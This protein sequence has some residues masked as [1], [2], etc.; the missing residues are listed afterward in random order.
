MRRTN[1]NRWNLLLLFIIIVFVFIVTTINVNV[2]G[3]GNGNGNGNMNTLE[4]GF[5]PKI[6]SFYRP[7]LRNTRLYIESF[8]NTYSYDYF[9]NIFRKVG[10][11]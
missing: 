2:N 8:S 6:R 7:H 1:S 10:L 4:E 9:I 11:Y 3:N 5:T